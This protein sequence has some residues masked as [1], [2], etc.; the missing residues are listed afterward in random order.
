MNRS[1]FDGWN[2]INERHKKHFSPRMARNSRM[3]SALQHWIISAIRTIRDETPVAESISYFVVD[4]RA[5]GLR[6]PG[7]LRGRRCSRELEARKNLGN[8]LDAI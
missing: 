4:Y 3:E 1:T 7:T 2:G 8:A 6:R 5:C